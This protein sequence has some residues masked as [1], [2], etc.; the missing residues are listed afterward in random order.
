M[1]R[2]YA[3]IQRASSHRYP[4]LIV[5]ESG[6]G[7]KLVA[8]SIH[9]LGSREHLPFVSMDC[10]ALPPILM[11]TELFGYAK[12]AFV[13][14]LEDKKGLA[15]VAGDGTLF[16]GEISQLTPKLQAKLLHSLQDRQFNP[17]GSPDWLP[18]RARVIAASRHD[19]GALVSSGAFREDLFFQLTIARI[20]LPPLRARIA[21]IPL[22]ASHFLEKHAGQADP[23]PVISDAAMECLLTYSWPG[24]VPE[25]ERAVRWALSLASGTVIELDDLPPTIRTAM[26]AGAHRPAAKISTIQGEYLAMIRALGATDGDTTAAASLL[27]I[28]ESALERRLRSYGL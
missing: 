12:D 4:V 25:L 5:G 10:S 1:R 7:K 14:T 27:Q 20:E 11:E 19:L 15:S 21:D 26:A 6:T 28:P 24:N 9:S 23:Q 22:L 13:R 18:F 17:V 2:L 3:A 8:S 16:L